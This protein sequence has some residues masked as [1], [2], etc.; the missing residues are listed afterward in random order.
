MKFRQTT[1][2]LL[3]MALCA[4]LLTGCGRSSAP[5]FLLNTEGKR[6]SDF[7]GKT[8]EE[9]KEKDA[10]RQN[11]V[12]ALTAMFGTPDDPYLFVDAKEVINLDNVRRAAGPFGGN[13]DGTQKGLF[14]QH[15]VHCHGISGD[16]AGP[17]AAFLNPYPRDYRRGIF[18]FK[19]TA[20]GVK[21]TDADL[22][23]IIRE[24]V[25]GTAMPSFLLLHDDEVEALVDY[26]KYL[27]I[28]GETESLLASLAESGDLEMTHDFLAEQLKS[29]VDMWAAAKDAVVTPSPYPET[30]EQK[31]DL[32]AWKDA[33]FD[34]AYAV[35]F[36]LAEKKDPAA[37]HTLGKSV[38]LGARAQCTKCHGP[39]GL[40][41]GTATDP[42][43]DLWNKEKANET[44]ERQAAL[45]E[46]RAPA[47]ALIWALPLQVSLPRNLRL[48]IYRGGRSPADLYR[49][50]HAGIAGVDMPE[51][52]K[53]LKPLEIWAVVDYVRSLPYE[54]IS[55]YARQHGPVVHKD[56][57]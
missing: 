21:P 45:A 14:R 6:P 47:E 20:P 35:A 33:K 17:T 37:W 43:Y 18:K 10:A 26:V 36:Q 4:A 13:A 48:D 19:S 53:A 39:T 34:E 16:G 50:V 44:K 24:G 3:A 40:G 8:A 38:F 29:P 57:M 28:R 7:V 9:Q 25:P 51:G 2:F 42:I 12:D 54:S 56:R 32:A 1:L 55:R 46:G 52:G 27:S 30:I 41:D 49:R 22:A 5:R 23:R 31:L 15:C 11:I